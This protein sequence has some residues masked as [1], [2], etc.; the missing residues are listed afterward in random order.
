M[1]DV[2]IR[3]ASEADYSAVAELLQSASLPTEGVVEHLQH[4]LVAENKVGIV[5]TIGLELYGDTA[6]LRSAVIHPS[7]QNKGLGTLLYNRLT[8]YAKSYRVRRLILLTDTAEKYFARKGFRKIDAKSVSGPITTSVEFTGACPSS[9]V[10][11]ELI[12]KFE[13]SARL[14]NESSLRPDGQ[15]ESK[16]S[17]I[18]RSSHPSASLRT[19]LPQND[20][21]KVLILC[22]GNSCR[23]QMAEAFL[24]SF[25]PKLEVHSAGT[26]PAL[27]V[28]PKAIAVMKE[29]SIDISTAT[30]KHVDQFLKEQ[31]DYVITV[32]DQAK[33]T[34][35]VFTG[36]VHQRLHIGFDDPAEATGSESEVTSEFRRI[37]DEIKQQFYRFYKSLNTTRENPS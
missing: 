36:Q 6:L 2:K 32:C 18:L 15:E 29:A 21:L 37:R 13:R 1:N 4:F 33:E 16:T 20:R 30:P 9:A 27:R 11:M 19:G 22:T 5:G 12:L 28:H 35:P 10:C 8:E 14:L 23:S 25:D 7:W 34:C 17:E 3:N 26:Q 31:F 24:K